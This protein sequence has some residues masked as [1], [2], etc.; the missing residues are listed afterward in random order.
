MAFQENIKRDGK[1]LQRAEQMI[2]AFSGACGLA[3]AESR[4]IASASQHHFRGNR[5]RS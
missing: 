2:S 5:W 1:L 4:A 3:L